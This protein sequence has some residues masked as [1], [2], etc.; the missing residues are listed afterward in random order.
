MRVFLAIAGVVVLTLVVFA[1]VRNHDFVAYD[2][3]AFV[4]EHPIVRQGLTAEGVRW[5]FNPVNAYSAAGGTLAWLSHMVDVEL[6]GIRPGPHHLVNLGLHALNAALLLLF[7]WRT[8]GAPGRSTF[9]AALFAVHPLHVESV[10]WVF[11]RKDVLSATFWMLTMLAY[12]GWVRQGGAARYAL[13]VLALIAGLMTKPVLVTMPFVLLLIDAWPLRRATLA[14]ADLA[15]W[16]SLVFEKI[17]LLIP[18]AAAAWF[19]VVAQ[20][21]IGAVSAAEA[22]PPGLRLENIVV[23]YSTY[24]VKTIWPASL[25]VFYPYPAVIPL[26]KVAASVILLGSLSLLAWQQRRRR[27][28]VTTGWLWYLGTLV[29][30]IGLIQVGS[31][32]RADRFTYLPLI[33][34]FIIVAWAVAEFAATRRLPAR[35]AGAAAC[36]VVLVASVAARAQ[37]SVWRNSETLWTHA[38]AVTDGNFRAY[39]GM[40]EV[41]DARG[42]SARAVNF[43]KE[44]L[45]LAPDEA[46]WHV[47]LGMLHFKRSEF[48]D[49]ALSF[50]RALQL[51]P[52]DA[53][54][55]NNLGAVLVRL[56]RPA[57]AVAHLQRA[58]SLEPG[59]AFARRNLGLARANAGDL[60]TGA[61]DLIEALKLSPN[62]AQWHFE[63]AAMLG[64]MNRVGDA[65]QH[66][67][68]A[69][70]LDP[71]HAA[72]RELLAQLAK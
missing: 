44:A 59:Y 33:G 2:D 32:A 13:V 21:S 3:P 71:A 38:L 22:I 65:V 1:P 26:W 10:A 15:R 40:A 29:P 24:L 52:D 28:F 60:S 49:A 5:T 54:T 4:Y 14:T 42:D 8:T 30:M 11:E 39:A 61:T 53:E 58:L 9:V 67:R 48:T 43:Y 35:I 45:R 47:N 6:F 19:T 25:A 16:R 31:H 62:E 12:A 17:P 37:V 50:Q 51:R 68:E 34:V 66:L 27:P 55:E 46:E 20:Q 23:S 18:V 57:E 70:R 7:L 63:L 36:V 69:V 72:A 41:A 64:R 56:D